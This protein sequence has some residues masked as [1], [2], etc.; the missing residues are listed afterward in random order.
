MSKSYKLKIIL[1]GSANSGKSTFLNNSV[2]HETPIG[3]SFKPV[4]CFVNDED[5]YK[6]VCWDLKVRERFQFMYKIF[7]RGACGALLC[8]DVSNYKSFN[9]LHMW[10]K[11]IRES[12][13]NIPIFLIGTKID[14]PRNVFDDDISRLIEKYN[15][16]GIYFASIHQEHDRKAII[17]RKL[18]EKLN[19]NNVISDFSIFLPNNISDKKFRTF[20]EYFSKC[21]LCDRENHFDYLK[22]FF[23]SKNTEMIKLKEKLLGLVKASKKIDKKYRPLIGIPCCHC[24]KEIFEKK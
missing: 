24:F 12:A 21:P 7:C 15:L 9:E 4:D 6:F 18:I 8:F 2:I 19:P 14:L 22:N 3:V 13:G 11:I 16:D 1:G 5:S 10:I 23:F 17:F 20:L